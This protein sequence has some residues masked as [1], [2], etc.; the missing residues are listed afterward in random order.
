V[1]R[2]AE[3]FRNNESTEATWKLESAVVWITHRLCLPLDEHE[4]KEAEHR[5]ETGHVGLFA[6]ERHHESLL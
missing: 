4:C 5:S 1:A 2:G 6:R 3:V